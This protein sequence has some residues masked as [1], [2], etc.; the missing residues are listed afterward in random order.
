MKPKRTLTFE[1]TPRRY[2]YMHMWC[3]RSI[4]PEP[5]LTSPQRGW[6]GRLLFA[7]PWLASCATGGM[8]T[9][10]A[11]PRS[12]SLRQATLRSSSRYYSRN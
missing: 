5:T 3:D 10:W 7:V 4:P 9:R 8:S 6:R 1:H 11:G 2:V 12:P